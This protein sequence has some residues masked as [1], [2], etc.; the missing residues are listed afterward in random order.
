MTRYEWACDKRITLAAIVFEVLM[1]ISCILLAD[2]INAEVLK[3]ETMLASHVS[4]VTAGVTVLILQ[5][6]IAGTELIARY[7]D[8]TGKFTLPLVFLPGGIIIRSVTM[9]GLCS[10]VVAI[11][12]IVY[13]I[14]ILI[15]FL[16]QILRVE[17]L[18]NTSVMVDY[19]DAFM[20]PLEKFVNDVYN[21]L[22]YHKIR[23][24][25]SVFTSVFNG[26]LSLWCI[27]H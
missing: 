18:L 20:E 3:N 7:R 27:N 2:A 11:K 5:Y 26:C 17:R 24:N 12:L 13:F 9:I 19:P 15:T 4:V 21:V 23:E 16:L 6:L 22:Y 8:N 10:V 25:S 14:S 1:V